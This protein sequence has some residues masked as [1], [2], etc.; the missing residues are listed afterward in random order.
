MDSQLKT[1]NIF[2][3]LEQPYDWEGHLNYSCG[4]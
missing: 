2:I 3:Y 4:F 1:E